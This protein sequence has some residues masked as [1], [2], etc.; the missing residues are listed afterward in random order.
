MFVYVYE[1]VIVCICVSVV[2]VHCDKEFLMKTFRLK[3]SRM[4][5]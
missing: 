5:K 2:R 4:N 3:K 1:S